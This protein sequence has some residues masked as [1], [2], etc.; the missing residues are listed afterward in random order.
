MVQIEYIRWLYHQQHMSIRAIAKKVGSSRK[1]VRKVLA[2]EDARDH[3]YPARSTRPCPVMGPVVPIIEHWLEEDKQRPKKQRHTA[4]RIYKRLKEEYGFKGSEESV[5]RV[6]RS[7]KERE[8]EK[9]RQV[10]IPLEF[11]LGEAAQCDW[12]EAQVLLGTQPTRVYIFTMRLCASRAIFVRAYLHQNQEAFFEG[13][14]LA[15]EFF[16]GVPKRVIYDNLKTAVKRVLEGTRREEQ[17]AFSALR[18]HY[19]FAAEFC[20]VGQAHEKGQAE[21]TIGL[22]RRNL[23]V[24]LPQCASLEELNSF[25]YTK[26][27]EYAQE[28]KV[29]GTDR[30]V[31]AVW[32][33]EKQVLL[34]LPTRP[35][36]C[37]RILHVKSDHYA[38]V[39]F[40]T[41]W[42]SVPVAHA[43]CFLTLKA[44]VDHLEI[45]WGQ[46]LVATHQRSYGRREEILDPLHYLPELE[47]KPRAWQNARPLKSGKLPPVYTSA[48]AELALRGSEGV[49]EFARI[50]QLEELFGQDILTRAL[51]RA[52][53]SRVLS[54]G[55][56]REYAA[57]LVRGQRAAPLSSLATHLVE[58]IDL[59]RF[60]S[61]LEAKG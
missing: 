29:P 48:L 17:E 43:G 4:R 55:A 5:R 25:L 46:E 61:L 24:P 6:V 22:V 32:E 60:N 10:Y 54:L 52:V 42:Y 36:A 28:F 13:H 59:E 16:G 30:T 40:E 19:V 50:M 44:Y 14:R 7:I 57:E 41:N 2:L 39:C 35:F 27:L 20:N 18:C 34:A 21:N 26:C 45:W 58:K 3:Q 49:K 12:G 37:C 56:V 47:K 15:F 11:A 31:A 51:E 38:R 53:G 33:E 8:R 23:F 1:T 9:E